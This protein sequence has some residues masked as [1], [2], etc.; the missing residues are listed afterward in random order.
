MITLDQGGILIW[1]RKNKVHVTEKRREREGEIT[2]QR[3]IAVEICLMV[4]NRLIVD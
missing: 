2:T 3:T 1:H 4:C